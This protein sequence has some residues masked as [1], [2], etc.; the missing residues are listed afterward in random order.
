MICL[1]YCPEGRPVNDFALEAEFAFLRT[2]NH[3]NTGEIVRYSTENIFN[4]V[5]EGIVDGEIPNDSV[6]FIFNEKE[7]SPNVYGTIHPW[8]NVF[9]AIVMKY[10]LPKF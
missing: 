3:N 6:V 2:M 1:E 7:F 8:P 4:R 5:R 9:Y 10:N